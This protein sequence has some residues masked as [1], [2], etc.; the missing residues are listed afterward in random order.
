[1]YKKIN[2]NIFKIPFV[3]DPRT[4]NF[5]LNSKI[6]IYGDAADPKLLEIEADKYFFT[7]YFSKFIE[8]N[9][10]KVDKPEH[11]MSGELFKEHDNINEKMIYEELF[12]DGS[13]MMLEEKKYTSED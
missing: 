9:I 5:K 3:L 1:M 7:N 8:K 12:N 6:G 13:N 10:V 4:K 11:Q 2:V